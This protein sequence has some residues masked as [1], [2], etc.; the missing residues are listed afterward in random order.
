[1]KHN[2]ARLLKGLSLSLSLALALPA[3]LASADTVWTKA[4]GSAA[5][6]FERP[7]VKIE[8]VE[9]GK[10][11]FRSS[12]R[13]TDKPLEEIW[14]IKLDSDPGFSGAEEA[15]A[16]EQWDKALTGYQSTLAKSSEAWV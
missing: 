15:F 5:K 3:A 7:N 10:L 2:H 11:Y 12:D 1:M 8:K 13:V 6:P 16:T 9:N 14:Q 4:P